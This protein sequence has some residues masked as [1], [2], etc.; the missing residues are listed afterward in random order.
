[1]C[2]YRCTLLEKITPTLYPEKQR[3]SVLN[4]TEP[5]FFCGFPILHNRIYRA[6]P[7]TITGD[8]IDA[9]IA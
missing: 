4:N 1:P 8:Q 2:P 7:T 6:Y 5:F 3:G 9:T